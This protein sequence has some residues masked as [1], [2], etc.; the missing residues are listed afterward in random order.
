[1]KGDKKMSE[2]N[3]SEQEK[4]TDDSKMPRRI[5]RIFAIIVISVFISLITVPMISWQIFGWIDAE[6]QEEFL[7]TG[8]SP[9]EFPREFDYETIMSELDSY[10]NRHIPYRSVIVEARKNADGSLEKPYLET[11]R[12][13]ILQLMNKFRDD[14]IVSPTDGTAGNLDAGDIFGAEEDITTLAEEKES[15]TESE[16]LPE[17]EVVAGDE[18][19]SHE[20]LEEAIEQEPSC[21]EFGV[22]RY[23][24]TDCSYSRREY[25]SKLAHNEEVIGR[26]EATCTTSGYV[27]YKCDICGT[28]REDTLKR[29]GH[30]YSDT[31]TFAATDMTYGYTEQICSI[32][33]YHK[34]TDFKKWTID[35]SYF[36]ESRQ[37]DAIFGRGDWLFYLGGINDY[38]AVNIPSEQDLQGKLAVLQELQSICDEKGI[39][40]QIMVMPNKEEVYTDFMP[41]Y[42]GN[43][44][45][46]TKKKAYTIMKYVTDNS[47]INYIYPL[48]ELR[49]YSQIWQTYYRHDTHWNHAGAFIGTQALY[50]AL[51]VPTTNI[52]NLDIEMMV[53]N[54]GDLI[55][56]G[57]LSTNQFNGDKDYQI[58]QTHISGY[59]QS[60]DVYRP[61]ATYTLRAR[62]DVQSTGHAWS[63]AADPICDKNYVMFSDSFRISMIPYLMKDFKNCTITHYSNVESTGIRQDI[64]DAEI[65]VVSAVERDQDMI[66]STARKLIDIYRSESQ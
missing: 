51:G 3:R 47:D 26:L 2:H 15:A 9:V 24:C 53:R 65:L 33:N 27:K 55:N 23:E 45:S 21:T 6:A 46:Y 50:E 64:L 4:M 44:V 11:I 32:C 18:N 17:D 41:T 25:M 22:R 28:Q 60:R 36:P 29:I 61:G 13:A 42:N 43:N 35:N 56:I 57:E 14:P 31:K 38:N 58:A 49:A 59:D 16:S 19:C 39:Q 10:F 62:S 54:G 34:Y 12:P 1:M 40:L 5:N 48:A 37:R 20:H 7:K 63:T 8:E 30:N 66:F 52:L